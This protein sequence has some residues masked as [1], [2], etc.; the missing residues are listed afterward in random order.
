MGYV[1]ILG[2]VVKVY[3]LPLMPRCP[4]CG[5]FLCIIL[6]ITF[7]VR[8]AYAAFARHLSMIEYFY[9]FDAKFRK[10]FRRKNAIEIACGNLEITF[11]LPRT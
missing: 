6:F 7:F 11:M 1:F 8:S 10:K 4:F 9:L 2:C 5:W 3:L